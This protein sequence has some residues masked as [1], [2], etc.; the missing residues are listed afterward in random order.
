MLIGPG[1]NKLEQRITDALCSGS[2]HLKESDFLQD[3]S[4]KIGFYRERAF[5]STLQASWL[6]KILT[7]FESGT[8]SSPSKARRSADS[9]R[10]T[11]PP[12]SPEDASE[13][14]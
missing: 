10:K 4:R 11:P 6:F 14:P 7:N 2:L 12:S 13:S 5:L 8:T 1:V 3:I 9:T